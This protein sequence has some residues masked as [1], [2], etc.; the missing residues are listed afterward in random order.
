MTLKQEA[1]AEIKDDLKSLRQEWLDARQRH[2]ADEAEFEK[3]YAEDFRRE[4]EA[5]NGYPDSDEPGEG[6]EDY[7]SWDDMP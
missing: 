2:L 4:W 5:E 6:F 3:T 7:P 1:K